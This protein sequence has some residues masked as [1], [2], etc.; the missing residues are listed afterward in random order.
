MSDVEPPPPNGSVA[1]ILPAGGSGQ[2]FG[3]T[4][5]KLFAL[6][7]GT[8]LWYHA[9]ARI[10]QQPEVGRIVMA[11]ATDDRPIY[12]SEF[13]SQ[14]DDLGIELVAG[15]ESRTQ[16]VQNGLDALVGDES[17]ACVAVHDAARPLV[18]ATD[19]A[20]VFAMGFRSGAAI[21]ATPIPGSVKRGVNSSGDLQDQEGPATQ[22]VDRRDLWIALTPQVFR[23]ELLAK[24]YAKFRGRPATD[25]AELVERIGHGVSLVR[26]SAENIKITHPED[27]LIAEAILK[28]QSNDA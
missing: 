16:S 21:L 11:V 5:N 25:D 24:A 17:V 3:A 10:R 27:L 28:R 19:L 14:L 6:L 7:D 2:R 4:R 1:A 12:E 26:G 22:S 18:S 9:A 8:P 15:G 13:S 23:L 20:A